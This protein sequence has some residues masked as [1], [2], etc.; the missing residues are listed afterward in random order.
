MNNR[1][2]IPNDL[3]P[4]NPA[5]GGYNAFNDLLDISEDLENFNEK[6]LLKLIEDNKDTEYGKKY[7]FENIRSIE[8]FKEKVPFSTYDDYAYEIHRMTKGEKNILTSYP[9]V[10]YA[11][12]SGSVDNPKNIPVSKQA[13]DLYKKYSQG[14]A[15]FT[16]DKGIRDLKGRPVNPGKQFQTGVVHTTNVEDGT[17]RGPISTAIFTEMKP[18]LNYILPWP[19]ELT[20]PEDYQLDLKYLKALYGLKDRSINSLIAPFLPAIIDSLYYI[21]KNWESLVEDIEKGKINP[22]IDI[23]PELREKFEAELVPDPERAAELRKEFETG[24]ETPI[25]PRIW[26]NIDY[27]S[28]IA[29]GSFATYL[30]KLNDY[31]GDNIPL[32]NNSYAAS[33][34][35]MA[36]AYEF[37]KEAYALIPENGFFEFIPIDSVDETK[38]LN[39]HELEEGKEYEIIITN[40][41]GFYRYK[42]GDVIEVVGHLGDIPLIKFKYR[43]NQMVNLAG[44][45][46]NES[47]LIWTIEQLEKESKVPI[48]DYSIYADS[49][50][51]PGRYILLI[52]PREHQ[53]KEM[54]KVLRD[55][56]DEKMG[57]ANPS[58]G[59]K[60]KDSILLPMSLEFVQ[61]ETYYLYRDLLLFR[62]VSENQI[63]PVHVIDTPR[64]E[65]FFFSLLDNEED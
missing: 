55:I 47:A 4:Q 45:K 24:F 38:T 9:I 51:L 5:Y 7:D 13:L 60:V 44:E 17:L 15:S 21:E 14:L 27:I 2:Q 32:Y 36:V 6:L 59:S 37:D 20:F 12:T 29:G 39:M 40:L 3:D 49:D 10:H 50:T 1:V 34:A 11:V 25:V 31:V 23:D 64:K 65:R 63:K 28:A 62:G 8:D 41:S 33:E 52:E 46:T 26:P 22:N 53:S 18:F 43:K 35:L 58:Y 19:I 16:Y 30:K 56:A 42:L 57:I 48:T 61:P 54:K